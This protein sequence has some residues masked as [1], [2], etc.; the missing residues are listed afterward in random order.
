M[1]ANTFLLISHAPA[2]TMSLITVRILNEH[3]LNT[4]TRTHQYQR[5]SLLWFPFDCRS[6][7]N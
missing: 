1:A 2:D 7:P 5:F 4:E 3:E 6:K